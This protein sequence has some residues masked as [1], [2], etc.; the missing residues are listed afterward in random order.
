MTDTLQAPARRTLGPAAPAAAPQRYGSFSLGALRLALPMMALREVLPLVP[1]TALPCEL[2]GLLGGIDLRGRTV[3][4]MDLRGLLG[5]PA[6]PPADGACVVVMV[7]DRPCGGRGLLGL[8]ADGV[9]S[10]FSARPEAASAMAAPCEAPLLFSHCI[11]ADDGQRCSVLQPEAVAALS[12]APVVLEQAGAMPPPGGEAGARPVPTL[13]LRCDKVLMAIDAVAVQSTLADPQLDTKTALAQG[14]C[15]GTA[16]STL[17]PVPAVDLLALVGLADGARRTPPQA[18]VVQLPTGAVA[19]M[20]DEVVD[21]IERPPAA[22][23]ALPALAVPQP[24]V[25]RGVMQAPGELPGTPVMLLCIEALRR[26][27]EL[28]RIAAAGR[29]KDAATLVG[30]ASAGPMAATDARGRMLVTFVLGTET[31]TPLDQVREILCYTP[32]LARF[33]GS[34]PMLGVTLHRGRAIPVMCLSRLTG[35]PPPEVTPAASVLVVE[36]DG[37]PVGFAVP[38]LAAIERARWQPGQPRRAMALVG[39][40][41][42]ERMLPLIDLQQMARGLT[43]A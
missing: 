27:D 39:Q 5:L 25:F 21:M 29:P 14:I 41:E 10:V 15:R 30:P 38:A 16:A 6:A 23:V 35:G 34:G 43:T 36:V 8:L 40:G 18:V 1:L 17:G 3:P 26:H 24:T 7:H 19:L 2:P 11:S 28:L 20:V 31:A 33:A 32:D 4:V 13:L 42:T 22:L 37:A 12:G 9:D